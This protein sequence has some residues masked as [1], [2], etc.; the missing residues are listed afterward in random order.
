MQSYL[1][2]IKL[3]SCHRY[4]IYLINKQY[5]IPFYNFEYFKYTAP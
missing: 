3:I 4:I 2:Y 5:N 1:K